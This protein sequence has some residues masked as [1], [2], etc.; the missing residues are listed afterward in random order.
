MS[1]GNKRWTGELSRHTN[2]KKCK[3][4]MGIKYVSSISSYTCCLHI[5]NPMRNWV[6]LCTELDSVVEPA[7]RHLDLLMRHG[8]DD[9]VRLRP[10]TDTENI[11]V[12]DFS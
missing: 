6:V 12:T 11:V 7:R 4:L 9:D 2:M 8:G 5:A 3:N 10:H 1:D